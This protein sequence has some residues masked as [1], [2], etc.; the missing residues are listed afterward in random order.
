[1]KIK[2]MINSRIAE[3]PADRR[4]VIWEGE[5]EIKDGEE[6]LT[7]V[8]IIGEG[9]P[10]PLVEVPFGINVGHYLWIPAD[11]GMAALLGDADYDGM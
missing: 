4:S 3:E 11:D 7:K 5:L 1:M 10:Q 9:Q 8:S 6:Y 2:I